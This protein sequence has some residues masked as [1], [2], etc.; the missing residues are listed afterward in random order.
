[1]LPA[2]QDYLFAP[3]CLSISHAPLGN[4]RRASLDAI[5]REQ[6]KSDH[7]D[8]TTA[9]FF[10]LAIWALVH[11]SPVAAYRI[12]EDTL[13]DASW[14]SGKN[15]DLVLNRGKA[16]LRCRH[17]RAAH[18]QTPSSRR[19][20]TN[21]KGGGVPRIGLPLRHCWSIEDHRRDLKGPYL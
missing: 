8:G 21:W 9:S 3:R 11:G 6:P 7:K 2:G 17:D 18:E 12:L 1:M 19:I 20:S 5:P 14:G 4:N 16:R 15:R 13:I 10:F